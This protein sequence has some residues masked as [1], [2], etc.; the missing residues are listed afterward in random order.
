[1][2]LFLKLQEP[3]ET[4]NDGKI[5]VVRDD[6]GDGNT[7]WGT[8]GNIDYSLIDNENYALFLKITITNLEGV[9]TE[10]DEIDFYT[11]YNK[12]AT[13]PTAPVNISDLVFNITAEDLVTSNIALG[14]STQA[15]PEGLYEFYYSVRLA[16][17]PV[18]T[19]LDDFTTF[20]LVDTN[21]KTKIYTY[22]STITDKILSQNVYK[23]PDW[24]LINQANFYYSCLEGIKS[25]LS[26]AEKNRAIRQLKI[27]NTLITN[28]TE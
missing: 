7:G 20:T 14:E 23:L 15:L 10:Y 18:G 21:T 3:I 6:T 17:D 25:N 19:E 5:L 27:L 12:N 1:M 9:T 8:S 24:E 11:L 22:L 16:G 4:T 2:A 13:I 26:L 28:K